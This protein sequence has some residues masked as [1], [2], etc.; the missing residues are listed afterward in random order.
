[1]SIHARAVTRLPHLDARGSTVGSRGFMADDIL[2]DQVADKFVYDYET[3]RQGGLIFAAVAFII[4]MLIIFSGK[5][6]C[7]RKKMLRA[8]GDEI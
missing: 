4:G 7:G 8:T 3:I 6:R 1:M 5:F 2:N